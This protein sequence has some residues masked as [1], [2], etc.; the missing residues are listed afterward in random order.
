MS[1]ESRPSRFR[2]LLRPVVGELSDEELVEQQ[3]R[4]A[5]ILYDRRDP[6]L[7]PLIDRSWD[8][9]LEMRERTTVSVPSCPGCGASKWAQLPDEPARCSE[10][11]REAGR[12]LEAEILE[13]WRRVREEL[14]G[15]T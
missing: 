1:T 6:A 10:C 8:I 12:A 15:S 7:S 3:V 9:R 14:E 11:D 13:A 5:K 4:L 2:D